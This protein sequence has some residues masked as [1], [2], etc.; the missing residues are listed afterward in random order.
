MDLTNKSPAEI[1]TLLA[2]MT[3]DELRAIYN[4]ALRLL[5]SGTPIYNATVGGMLEAQVEQLSSI[6]QTYHEATQALQVRLQKKTIRMDNLLLENAKLRAHATAQKAEVND[7]YKSTSWR[8][9]A[10]LRKIGQLLQ[11]RWNI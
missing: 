7:I 4:E 11:N 2:N 10:P 8:I 9:T 6:A 1:D 3:E 5:P